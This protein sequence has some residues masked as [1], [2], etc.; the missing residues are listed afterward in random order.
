[1][2]SKNLYLLCFYLYHQIDWYL[3]LMRSYSSTIISI[4]NIF[5]IVRI[6]MNEKTLDIVFGCLFGSLRSVVLM[7]I[8]ETNTN[9]DDRRSQQMANFHLSI[10]INKKKKKGLM[11]SFYFSIVSNSMTNKFV[12]QLLYYLH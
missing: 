2:F 4:R 7:R 9:Q 11:Q 12:D 1:M 8:N 5:L 3:I 10:K 6:L